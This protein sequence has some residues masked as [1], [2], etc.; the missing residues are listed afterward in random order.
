MPAR[1]ITQ[2]Q[3]R[4]ENR[5]IMDALEAGESFVIT[6][7][8]VPVAKMTPLRR[9]FFV[10]K[11]VVLAVFRNAP[12]IDLARMRADLDAVADQDPTPGA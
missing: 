12:D 1:E 8:G 7:N 4:K 6:R 9:R 5:E 3:L 2:R 10:P 11:E